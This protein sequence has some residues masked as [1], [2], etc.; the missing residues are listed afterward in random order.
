MYTSITALTPLVMPVHLFPVEA[1]VQSAIHGIDSIIE[2]LLEVGCI[3]VIY[4]DKDAAG[5]G[6][7]KCDGPVPFSPYGVAKKGVGEQW[8]QACHTASLAF[9]TQVIPNPIGQ[10]DNPKLLQ[11]LFDQWSMGKAPVITSPEQYQD[12]ISVDLL[13]KDYF[14]LVKALYKGKG[15]ISNPS[16]WACPV[17]ALVRRAAWYWTH[18]TGHPSPIDVKPQPSQQPNTLVNTDTIWARHPDWSE[19]QFW[20][21]LI[22]DYQQS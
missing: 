22:T 10:M 4:S 11:Y 15:G 3:G 17:E 16:G 2:G 7:I 8:A 19:E 20:A 21:E 12:N 14:R 13:A 5:T 18:H 9:W 1:R 6:D